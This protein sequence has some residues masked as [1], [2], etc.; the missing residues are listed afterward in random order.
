MFSKVLTVI[1]L[2]FLVF[3]SC[4]NKRYE[5]M[6][7][8]ELE[9]L[10]EHG[11]RD[12]LPLLC[13]KYGE[14]YINSKDFSDPII[15]N[16]CFTYCSKSY[17]ETHDKKSAYYLSI[18]YEILC[19]E[20]AKYFLNY[21]YYLKLSGSKKPIDNFIKNDSKIFAIVDHSF[22]SLFI[23]KGAKT[24]YDLLVKTKLLVKLFKKYIDDIKEINTLEL[25]ADKK[26]DIIRA[27]ENIYNSFVRLK[28]NM[29]W[30]YLYVTEEI[31]NSFESLINSLHFLIEL[32]NEIKIKS[33]DYTKCDK[34]IIIEISDILD[35][36]Q[37]NKEKYKK[38]Y[39]KFLKKALKSI[40]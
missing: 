26:E 11:R 13:Y 20:N 24:H 40:I 28:E 33:Y 1:M 38:E 16:K 31:N 12:L 5:K 22:A 17:N 30:S 2:L 6:E 19:F 9:V 35:N 39:N 7:P 23:L 8:E 36:F 34:D 15:K 18:Y 37:K 4:D 21:I 10:Y 25:L 14:R 27:Y 29:E 3:V 32:I